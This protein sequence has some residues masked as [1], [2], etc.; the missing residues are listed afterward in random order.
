MDC[1]APTP[2][3]FHLVTIDPY[4]YRR[5]LDGMVRRF[6]VWNSDVFVSSD[7]EAAT[8]DE[9]EWAYEILWNDLPYIQRA[10]GSVPISAV[11][12]LIFVAARIDREEIPDFGETVNPEATDPED[13]DLEAGDLEADDLETMMD[14]LDHDGVTE[15]GWMGLWTQ[16]NDIRDTAVADNIWLAILD[17]ICVYYHGSNQQSILNTMC[18]DRLGHL[19][20]SSCQEAWSLFVEQ[21]ASV[22]STDALSQLPDASTVNSKG[23]YLIIIQDPDDDLFMRL[24]VGQSSSIRSRVGQHKASCQDD[25]KPSLL[26]TTAQTGR[27]TM[28]FVVLG[29]ISNDAIPLH[30]QNEWLNIGEQFWAIVLQTLQPQI[31][32]FWLPRTMEQAP[33]AGLNVAL[34]IYQNH[35]DKRAKMGFGLLF[36]STDPEV[37]AYAYRML[38]KATQRSYEVQQANLFSGRTQSFRQRPDSRKGRTWR[39]A[40]AAEG[41]ALTVEVICMRCKDKRSIQIDQMPTYALGGG[42]YIMRP[43]RWCQFCVQTGQVLQSPYGPVDESVARIS[44]QSANKRSG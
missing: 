39:E 36:K 37:L 19:F 32:D 6:L 34:P 31:L 29:T 24:Y 8:K 5:L 14:C 44:R 1:H 30:H 18:W 12:D 17:R 22:R 15:I 16:F 13:C 33:W 9:Q 3:L 25:R 35:S 43:K 4:K 26:S 27:R 23:W 7:F 40:D 21:R 2:E 11:L 42:E 41:D 38:R 10:F 20:K 28:K